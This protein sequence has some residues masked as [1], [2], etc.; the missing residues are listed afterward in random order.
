MGLILRLTHTTTTTSTFSLA[1]SPLL[2]LG[3]TEPRRREQ[4]RRRQSKTRPTPTSADQSRPRR[5]PVPIPSCFSC[6]PSPTREGVNAGASREGYGAW[7]SGAW[8]WIR[9][10]TL[11]ETDHFC[12]EQRVRSSE[13][14]PRNGVV[15]CS[16]IGAKKPITVQQS[17]FV[18]YDR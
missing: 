2:H 13:C 10:E 18:D 16:H 5:R 12:S 14:P 6:L 7:G 4:G 1:L 11:G 3:P 8:R 9:S 15:S 17:V